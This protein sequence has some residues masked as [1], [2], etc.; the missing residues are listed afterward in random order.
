M[1]KFWSQAKNSILYLSSTNKSYNKMH[2]EL[3]SHSTQSLS[4][5]ITKW[6]CFNILLIKTKTDK[7]SKIIISLFFFLSNIFKQSISVLWQS[8]II[9]TWTICTLI[10]KLNTYRIFMIF[11]YL[12]QSWI[13]TRNNGTA[14]NTINA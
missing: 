10:G 11:P 12:Q 3:E 9:T 6:K 14:I 5:H 13:H 8:I 7:N 1:Y 2:T 4:I